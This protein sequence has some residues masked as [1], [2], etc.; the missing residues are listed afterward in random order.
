MFRSELTQRLEARGYL[1][2]LIL[3]APV[4]RSESNE[5]ALRKELASY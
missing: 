1:N 4:I 3:N 2:P 5:E